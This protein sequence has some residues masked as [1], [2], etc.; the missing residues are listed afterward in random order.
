MAAKKKSAAK[1]TPKKKAT[2]SQ[3]AAPKKAAKKKAA[4]KKKVAAKKAPAAAK[5]TEKKKSAASKSA[6]KAKA[7]SMDVNHGHVF[8]LRPRVNTS[9]RPNDFMA[10]K[11]ALRDEQYATIAEAAQAVAEEALSLTR[12]ESSRIDTNP[13]R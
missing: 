5:K 1:S 3:K 12:G 10:A 6:S 7:S 13:R 2:A 11:R 8:S 9:F 4:A